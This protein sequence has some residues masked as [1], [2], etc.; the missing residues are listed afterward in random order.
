MR[1]F[2]RATRAPRPLMARLH[3]PASKMAKTKENTR[4][5][6]TAAKP[7]GLKPNPEHPELL[8]NSHNNLQE[9]DRA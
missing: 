1:G 5:K 4:K 9:R 7:Q 2:D 6:S 8:S 3:F